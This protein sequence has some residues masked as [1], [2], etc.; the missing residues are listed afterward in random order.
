MLFGSLINAHSLKT[1]LLR[2]NSHTII[3]TSE[4]AGLCGPQHNPAAGR[5]LA[6]GTPLC[7]LAAAPLSRP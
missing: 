3:L 5:F 2:C 4:G 7:P 1:A 6:P